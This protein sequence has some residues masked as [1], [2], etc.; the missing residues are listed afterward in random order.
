MIIDEII[1]Q[2]RVNDEEG[3]KQLVA[4]IVQNVI[5]LGS[6][7][8]EDYLSSVTSDSMKYTI[9][10]LF[11]QLCEMGYLI[12]ISKLHYTPIEDLW[13]FLYEKHYK[14]IPRNS[15]CPI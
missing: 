6:L 7:T 9:S 1:T 8:V 14:N 3:H 15:R 10:S 5:S 2:M 4:E 12:Q 11:V 13:Q